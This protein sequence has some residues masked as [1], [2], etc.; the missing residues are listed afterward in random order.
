VTG[1]LLVIADNEAIARL[2]P[3]WAERFAAAG[4]GY[5]VRLAGSLGDSEIEAVVAEARSLSA[6]AI[7]AAGGPAT[8]AL[9]AAAATRLG[10]P[11]VRDEAA[12]GNGG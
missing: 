3:R 12:A 10:L 5:R 9:A 8:R 7:L 6:S 11:V 2:A 1:L 4:T